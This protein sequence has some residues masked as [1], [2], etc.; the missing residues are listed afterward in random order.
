MEHAMKAC[1]GD[2]EVNDTITFIQ[3]LYR[4]HTENTSRKCEGSYNVVNN[5]HA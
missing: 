3:I 1:L 2:P 4:L 5:Y